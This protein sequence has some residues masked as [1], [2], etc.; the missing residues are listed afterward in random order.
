MTLAILIRSRCLDRSEK[1]TTSDRFASDFALGANVSDGATTFA[2][3]APRRKVIL[4]NGLLWL[5]DKPGAA[6]GAGAPAAVLRAYSRE[7]TALTADLHSC[8]SVTVDV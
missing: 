4:P 1:Q 3:P 5:F 7:Q 6:A 8:G 2:K